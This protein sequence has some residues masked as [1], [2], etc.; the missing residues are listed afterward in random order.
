MRSWHLALK[1]TG[2]AHANLARANERVAKFA[3]RLL[4]HRG[5]PV[6]ALTALPSGFGFVVDRVDPRG[7]ERHP[8]WAPRIRQSTR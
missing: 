4:R 2:L 7:R 8:A 3:D 6:R 5:G 1:R